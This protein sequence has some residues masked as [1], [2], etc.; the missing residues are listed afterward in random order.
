ML[1]HQFRYEP[2]T[3]SWLW[4]MPAA[5]VGAGFTFSL[6]GLVREMRGRR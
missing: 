4:L 2:S 5:A 3:I 1:C 6:I